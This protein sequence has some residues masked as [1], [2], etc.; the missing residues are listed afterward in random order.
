MDINHYCGLCQHCELTTHSVIPYSLSAEKETNSLML[1]FDIGDEEVN[2][3]TL[4]FDIHYFLLVAMCL[5]NLISI[6][7]KCVSHS[8]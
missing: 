2:S 7:E 6:V 8:C 1:V 5:I 4:K 3:Y